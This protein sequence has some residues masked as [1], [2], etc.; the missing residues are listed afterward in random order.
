M[1][2]YN[3][4][5][6]YNASPT[7]HPARPFRQL[8]NVV[9]RGHAARGDHRHADRRGHRSHGLEIGPLQHAVAADVGVNDCRQ[10]PGGALSRQFERRQSP[11]PPAILPWRPGRALASMPSTTCPANARTPPGTMPATFKA[12]V[13]MIARSDAP[14]QR[15]GDV[16][17]GAQAA[18]KLTRH[19]RMPR[20][21]DGYCRR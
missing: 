21:C 15:R 11:T 7:M 20:Q 8:A 10:R 5:G 14:R 13:P 1:P 16:L 3:P 9:Q 4:A 17:L 12:R 2:S 18:A 6:P 19:A